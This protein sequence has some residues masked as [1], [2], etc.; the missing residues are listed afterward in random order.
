[1]E[2]TEDPMRGKLARILLGMFIGLFLLSA[3]AE[4]V[5][6]APVASP[7]TAKIVLP[8][9]WTPTAEATAVQTPVPTT[10]PTMELETEAPEEESPAP[11]STDKPA[12]D[13]LH[14]ACGGLSLEVEPAL[15]LNYS[16]ETIEESTDVELQPHVVAPEFSRVILFGYPS[17]STI[18]Y[19]A[20][21]IFPIQRFRELSPILVNPRVTMLQG[22]ISGHPAGSGELPFLPVISAYQIFHAQYSVL[23]FFNG[24][25]IRF[26]TMYNLDNTPINNEDLFYTFQG[27]TSDQKY[28]ISV[29]LPISHPSLPATRDYLPGG[30]WDAFDANPD[31]YF[32]QAVK[33]LNAQTPDR[34]VPSIGQLDS[35]VRS[36][37][38][39]P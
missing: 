29:S 18:R 23:P 8:P 10:S 28:W 19:P 24:S 39:T 38:M 5:A 12:S 26:L 22:L 9:A 34:F 31:P 7:T 4:P 3:C 33:D 14:I 35:L 36:M 1:M 11:L 25:G 27:M 30:D 15:A 16:C 20:I 6:E 2:T 21:S 17:E 13:P 32:A 37:F